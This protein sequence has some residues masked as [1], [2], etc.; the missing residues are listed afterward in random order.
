MPQSQLKMVFVIENIE[1]VTIE[2]MDILHF[3]EV[4]QDI[5]QFLVD[6]VLTE[7]NLSHG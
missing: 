6:C 1:K 5:Q 7:F 2:R 4:V 3:R